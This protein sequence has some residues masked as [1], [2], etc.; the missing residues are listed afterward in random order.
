M[1]STLIYGEP[2]AEATGTTPVAQLMRKGIKTRPMPRT[3]QNRQGVTKHAAGQPHD[4]VIPI[5]SFVDDVKRKVVVRKML[6]DMAKPKPSHIKR[7]LKHLKKDIKNEELLKAVRARQERQEGGPGSGPRPGQPHPHVGGKQGYLIDRIK[8]LPPALQRKAAAHLRQQSSEEGGPGSGVRGHRTARAKFAP[9]RP[10]SDEDR[11][12]A[13]FTRR[14]KPGERR[15]RIAGKPVDPAM[16]RAIR[17]A[18][19]AKREALVNDDSPGLGKVWQKE[20]VNYRYSESQAK[21][22]GT[23]SMFIAPG[24]CMIVAGLIRP[25]DVCDKW[26]PLDDEKRRTGLVPSQL[27]TLDYQLGESALDSKG[28]MQG[29]HISTEG[30]TGPGGFNVGHAPGL[31]RN[32]VGFT[33]ITGKGKGLTVQKPRVQSTVI[34][35]RQNVTLSEGLRVP[36]RLVV[37]PQHGV[38][39]LVQSEVVDITPPLVKLW[40]RAKTAGELDMTQEVSPPGWEGTVKRMKRH[41]EITNPWALAWWMKGQGYTPHKKSATTE[42]ASMA[43]TL[44]D[45]PSQRMAGGDPPQNKRGA[46]AGY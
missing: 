12:V 45:S 20:E 19:M 43:D 44:G 15:A 35:Q 33:D 30:A 32:P 40:R 46:V 42:M 36:S 41:G 9:E 5:K 10:E 22:C 14:E 18:L 17:K 38:Q 4:R 3:R 1:R 24:T 29:L 34:K 13:T 39:E 23:C 2:K 37:R 11:Q 25:V 26:A 27:I 8:Q 6:V 28:G 16:Q 21:S 31:K 7:Q